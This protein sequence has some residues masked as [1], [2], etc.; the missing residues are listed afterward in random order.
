MSLARTHVV[1][2][3]LCSRRARAS[4]APRRGAAAPSRPS[5]SVP[6]WKRLL[7]DWYDGTINNDLS[8]PLLPAGDQAP[9]GRPARSTAARRTTSSRRAQAAIDEQADA[10]RARRR[11][12]TGA[13]TTASTTP[14]DVDDDHDDRGRHDARHDDHDDDRRSSS[15][16]R[17]RRRRRAASR[18]RSTGITPGDP[19]SFPLPLLILGALAI[20]LVIAGAAGMLWQRSHPRDERRRRGL[21]APPRRRP[22]SA[23]GRLARMLQASSAPSDGRPTLLGPPFDGVRRAPLDRSE[24]WR[25]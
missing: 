8:D 2:A 21:D 14:A 18:A 25:P 13:S 4:L 1:R 7:N 20:L 12:T 16:C 10:A 19:D 15:R 6:C 24:T 23:A 9:A 22:C 11:T 17:R 5:V 3:S